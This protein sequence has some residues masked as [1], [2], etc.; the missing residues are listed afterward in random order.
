MKNSL[1]TKGTASL[2]LLL[3]LVSL[4]TPFLQA[5]AQL[6]PSCGFD[7]AR[8]TANGRYV[9]GSPEWEG[10]RLCDFFVL[11]NNVLQ[12]LFLVLIPVGAVIMLVV[13]GFMFLVSA[14]NPTSLE[15]GKQVITTTIKGLI[16]V[17]AAWL[18]VDFFFVALGVTTWSGP[19]QGWFTI[20]CPVP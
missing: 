8:G 9:S 10:C 19:G 2:F 14:G 18:V 16:I 7:G 5:H 12:F 3:L 1:L 13:G 20:N 4:G 6:T 15:K 17:Y 11:G